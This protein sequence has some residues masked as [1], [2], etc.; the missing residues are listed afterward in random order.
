MPDVV[1]NKFKKT[2]DISFNIEEEF[3]KTVAQ[4]LRSKIVLDKSIHQ[5]AT[6]CI[7]NSTT[8]LEARMLSKLLSDDIE[9]RVKQFIN[10]LG[11]TSKN[12]REWLIEDYKQKLIIEIGKLFRTL[13]F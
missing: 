7:E 10:C 9:S 5:H 2:K 12:Y 8:L 4:N 6:M 13:N 11:K 3:K 1:R